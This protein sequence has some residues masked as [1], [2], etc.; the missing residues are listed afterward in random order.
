MTYAFNGSANSTYG[1]TAVAGSGA[2]QINY[3]LSGLINGDNSTT[4]QGVIGAS[5]NGTGR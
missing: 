4:V 2:G 1:T 3:A 5:L